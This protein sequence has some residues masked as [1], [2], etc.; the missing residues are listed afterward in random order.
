M[1]RSDLIMINKN[2][3]TWKYRYMVGICAYLKET[4]KNKLMA[5]FMIACGMLPVAFEYDGTFL[6][7]MLFFAIPLFITRVNVFYKGEG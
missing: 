2:R 5:I 1:K 6:L 7:L 3:K 4:W